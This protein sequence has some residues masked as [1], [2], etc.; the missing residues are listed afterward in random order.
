[1]SYPPKRKKWSKAV[2]ERVRQKFGGRCAYCGCE[3]V[4]RFAL[5]HFKPIGVYLEAVDVEENLYPA[6][7]SC[8]HYKGE[9]D[10]ETM[11]RF[12]GRIYENLSK[13]SLTARMAVKFGMLKPISEVKFW[14]E[15]Y[16]D[17]EVK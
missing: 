7:L 11:R 1:M 3:L 13:Q 17:K 6:C 8:N 9:E 14:F 2:R 15:I 5:D 16:K 10:I 4:D 12:I